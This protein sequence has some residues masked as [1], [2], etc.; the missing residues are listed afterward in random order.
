MTRNS[1]ELSQFASFVE[2][3]DANQ[4]IG[5]T[6]SLVMLGGVGIGST[7]GDYL[8]ERTSRG[9]SADDSLINFNESYLLDDVYIEGRLNVDDGSTAAITGFGATFPKLNVGGLTTTRDLVVTGVTTLSRDTGFGTVYIG[10]ASVPVATADDGP[11]GL[12]NSNLGIAVTGP[13]GTPIGSADGNG[14]A[15]GLVVIDNVGAGDPQKDV[16]L[17]VSGRVHFNG[18][19]AEITN[20]T[21]TG[22]G[23]E[24]VVAPK[25]L[26]YDRVTVMEGIDIVVVGNYNIVAHRLCVKMVSMPWNRVLFHSH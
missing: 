13:G 19:N 6:T 17:Y 21:S 20:P 23:T 12:G 14:V 1:R 18:S 24:F 10:Q 8:T 25:S 16:A 7:V 9:S 11:G 2:V 4:N 5:L 26:F 22:L 3:R 15:H